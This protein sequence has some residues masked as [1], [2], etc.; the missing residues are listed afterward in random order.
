MNTNGKRIMLLGGNYFQMTAT[1]A[2]KELGCYVISVDYLPD[3]P[4]H[5]LADAYYNV[6][7]TDQ[8]MVL[9]LAEELQIDGIVS[10]ASDVAAPTAA[11]VAEQMGLPTNPYL[12][13]L[14]L[15]R[16]DLF[17]KFMREQGFPVPRG[18]SFT[19]IHDAAAFAKTLGWSVVVK[20][21]DSSGSKGVSR[22]M[23][24]SEMEGA[25]HLAKRYSRCG[26]VVVE[27]FIQRDGFQIAGDGFLADG[28]LIFTGYMNEHFDPYANPLVPIGESYPSVLP[29]D[30]KER[31]GKEIGK[32]LSLLGMRMGAVNLD[33]I[34]T[35]DGE[36]YILEI[37]PRNGGNLITDIIK[38]AS[39]LDLARYT[40][41]AALGQDCTGLKQVSVCSR[42]S[43]YI[44]HSCKDG[45]FSGLQVSDQLKRDLV[46][47]KLFVKKGEKIFRYENGSYGI[48]VM[49]LRHDSDEQMLY[50][51]EHMEEF[52][53]VIVT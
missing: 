29:K 24:Q 19:N 4:A 16:K 39:G 6:S 26:T 10:Y 37:G 14:T 51:M 31:A 17:R 28:K 33:F 13:V 20:P 45:I 12:S 15:T 25:Y 18:G 11:Y 47:C 35:K 42:I 8:E 30:L 46:L 22:I 36:I 3:N 49:L 27:E 40:I 7:T 23:E 41:L 34:V 43:S 44:I 52:L 48:G 38:Q 50:R 32:L 5:K 1:K 53:K 9:K 2:A 21:S